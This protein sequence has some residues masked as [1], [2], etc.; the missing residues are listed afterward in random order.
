MARPP[1]KDPSKKR[2]QVC[3]TLPPDLISIARSRGINLSQLL[4]QAI[5]SEIRRGDD[6]TGAQRN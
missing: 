1:M 2:K 4:E 3:V 5:L 6:N